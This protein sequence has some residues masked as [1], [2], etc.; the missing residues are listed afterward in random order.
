MRRRERRWCLGLWAALAG[1]SCSLDGFDGPFLE[2]TDVTPRAVQARQSKSG[3]QPV[4]LEELDAAAAGVR[5]SVVVGVERLVQVV[6]EIRGHAPTRGEGRWD[7]YGPFADPTG[8]ALEWT[9]WVRSGD[10]GEFVY[11]FEVAPSG[12]EAS[13][14]VADVAVEELDVLGA[15]SRTAEVI[16]HLDALAAHPEVARAIFGE[17]EGLG[18]EALRVR[19]EV[20]GDERQLDIRLPGGPE[21]EHYRLE[22]SDSKTA[23]VHAAT[24][25]RLESAQDSVPRPAELDAVWHPDRGG[26]ARAVISDAGWVIEECFTAAGR[27]TWRGGNEALES[28]WP[29]FA[30]GDPENC[31]V[32]A[33]AFDA[34]PEA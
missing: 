20:V 24:R 18:R 19:S 34:L 30:F 1:A 9:V 2:P 12:S 32:P 25:V 23:R 8:Q 21:V 10:G 16:V 17:F 6:E 13:L 3:P 28:A 5:A 14:R 27:L 15:A 31:Q 29:E 26:R 7:V 4:V 33:T 22:S 11:G